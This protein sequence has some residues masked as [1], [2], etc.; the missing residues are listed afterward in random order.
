MV[1][2]I[3]SDLA[4]GDYVGAI[5]DALGNRGASA[6][7]NLSATHKSV[8]IVGTPSGLSTSTPAVVVSLSADAQRA[9]SS[10][11]I[12]VDLLTA[13]GRSGTAGNT[14]YNAPQKSAASSSKLVTPAGEQE[15]TATSP[16]EASPSIGDIVQAA[17][18]SLGDP[19]DSFYN[20]LNSQQS[21]EDFSAYMP[22][23]ERTAFLSAFANKTLSIQNAADI[24]GLDYTDG[25]T[26]TGTSETTHFS[27]NEKALEQYGQSNGMYTSMI[28]MPVIGALVFSFP[29][30]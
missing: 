15:T 3:Q 2:M 18:N 20:I 5:Q 7:M 8:S 19:K 13:A 4:T 26:L 28:M 14:T 21:A 6:T 29:K 23:D 24:P 11:Q 10:G 12:A 9:L 16:T 25:T 27:Y 30:P 17:Q 1:S 22:D